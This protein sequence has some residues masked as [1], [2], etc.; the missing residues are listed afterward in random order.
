M[1]IDVAYRAYVNAASSS[2]NSR[3]SRVIIALLVLILAALVAV[4]VLLATRDN[5]SNTTAKKNPAPRSTT[6]STVNRHAVSSSTTTIA[7]T[8][9]GAGVTTTTLPQDPEA[10]AK[11]FYADWKAGDRAAAAQIASADAV[12]QM[13]QYPYGP[14]PT[15]SGPEDPYLFQNCQ[16]A[17]GSVICTWTGQDQALNILVR[18]V[19]GGLPVQVESVQRT[20]G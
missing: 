5:R 14:I 13:F 8:S 2:P 11:A 18:N 17:A 7:P 6:T 19:T 12:S 20:G 3:T 10:Y 1:L 15:N 9:S 16:G 4:I